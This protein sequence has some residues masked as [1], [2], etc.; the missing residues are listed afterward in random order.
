MKSTTGVKYQWSDIEI[1]FLKNNWQSM[2]NRELAN[3][4]DLTLTITRT[5]LYELGLKRIDLEY[6]TDDQ[7][8]YL[9]DH[10]K[11]TG[12]TELAEIF[13]NKWKKEKGWTKKHI[14]KKRRYLKLKRSKTEI[15]LIREVWRQ[16][17]LF[18]E[19]NR[20]MW[21]TRGVAKDGDIRFW[22]KPNVERQYPVIKV[23]GKFVHWGN[24][25]WSQLN[26]D[27]PEGMNVVF[28]DGNPHNMSDDNLILISNAE[29]SKRNS[30]ISSIGLS[31]NYV[32]GIM[33][34]GQPELRAKIKLFPG[35]ILAKRAQ[36]LLQREI[37]KHKSKET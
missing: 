34:Q 7:V 32:A 33:T 5:K 19:S 1:E 18:K 8:K 3:S 36:L 6:W 15:S 17:G 21:V 10:Y 37:N 30:K 27:V 2:S 14:E 9:I 16:K 24:W 22:K 12:D 13:N 31:D 20:K 25:R 29:L 35:I 28:K 26:G 23:N 4:L 11:S